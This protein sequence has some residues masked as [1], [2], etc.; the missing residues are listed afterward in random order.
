MFAPKI[1]LKVYFYTHPIYRYC[2]VTVESDG[3]SSIVGKF[4]ATQTQK[5]L[6]QFLIYPNSS[7]PNSLR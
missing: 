1:A 7:T 3:N 6:Y 5:E 2:D 4:I